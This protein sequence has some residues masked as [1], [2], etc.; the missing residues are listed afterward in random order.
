LFVN[1]T[2][3]PEPKPTLQLVNPGTLTVGVLDQSNPSPPEIY[4]DQGGNPMG[5]D[6]DLIKKIAKNMHLEPDIKP[7]KQPLGDLKNKQVDVVISA[8]PVDTEG[9]LSVP[10]LAPKDVLLVRKMDNSNQL[11]FNSWAELCGHTI[12]VQDN[13]T[14]KE[15]SVLTSQS[16]CSLD[17]IMTVKDDYSSAEKLA[18]ALLKK[19]VDAIYQNTPIFAYYQTLSKYSNKFEQI[20]TSHTI[21]GGILIRPDNKPLCDSIKTAFDSL[22]NNGWYKEKLNRTDGDLTAD[23][24]RSNPVATPIPCQ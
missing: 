17:K 6:I 8:Y 2:T 22:V 9:N 4:Y 19:E 14:E 1:L 23:D 5:F 16:Q 13:I 18:D 24:V 20:W 3:S 10:Y 21:Q 11:E 7:S 12:G 15:Q